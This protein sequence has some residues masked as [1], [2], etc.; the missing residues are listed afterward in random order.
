MR[1]VL[2]LFA[3][4][5]LP[6]VSSAQPAAPDLSGKWSGY[7]VSDTNGHTGPLSAK[8]APRG[9]DSYRVTFRGR[10]AV[11]VPFR[12]S[13]TMNVVGTGDGVVVLSAER[14]LGPMGTFRTTAT[15]TGTNFNATFTSRRDSG[16]F[17]M[18]RR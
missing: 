4:L 11:I 16:R 5:V 10:F 7:W 2:S 12:Y 14:R 9:P 1:R 3:V 6:A 13:T 8:F 15:A 17:V 18:T